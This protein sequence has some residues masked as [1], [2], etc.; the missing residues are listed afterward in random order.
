MCGFTRKLGACAAY[1][2]ELWVVLTGL[3]LAISK[4]YSNVIVECDSS[5]VVFVLV[6]L[7][8][9]E[10]VDARILLM[11]KEAMLRFANIRVVQCAYIQG[12]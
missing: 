6:N 3:E 8:L 5:A 7:Q 9:E 4:Q 11:I 12:E 10:D 1:K 2:S